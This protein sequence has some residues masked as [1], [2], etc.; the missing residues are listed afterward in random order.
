M[1]LEWVACIASPISI[2]IDRFNY[3]IFKRECV[4]PI[5]LTRC[6]E[7]LKLSIAV[8][9]KWLERTINL[10]AIAIISW[11]IGLDLISIKQ[12]CIKLAN[13]S[14]IISI[15]TCWIIEIAW[16]SV[17]KK[18][19]WISLTKFSSVAKWAIVKF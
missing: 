9:S 3:L 4:E 15:K 19:D 7:S 8:K 6:S 16:S 17:L 2:I 18:S 10:V 14:R 5:K 11:F 12:R 1:G 13:R